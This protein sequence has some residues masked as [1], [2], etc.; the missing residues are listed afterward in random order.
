FQRIKHEFQALG[1]ERIL[2][3]AEFLQRQ[4][5]DVLH[6]RIGKAGDFFHPSG[7]SVAILCHWAT[8]REK[9]DVERA[10]SA[11]C[12]RMTSSPDSTH[13]P[14][15]AKLSRTSVWIAKKEARIE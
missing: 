7:R 14:I 12:S 4:R 8:H 15:P 5:L 2:P 6:Q 3:L 13:P 1:Q 11:D 9:S 10:L